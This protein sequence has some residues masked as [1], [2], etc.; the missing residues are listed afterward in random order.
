MDN[1][2]KTWVSFCVWWYYLTLLHNFTN[3]FLR[4]LLSCTCIY[5]QVLCLFAY[6]QHIGKC[7][8]GISHVGFGSYILISRVILSIKYYTSARKEELSLL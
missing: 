6:K 2:C 5:V 8:I 4:Y 3:T 7:E 1:S